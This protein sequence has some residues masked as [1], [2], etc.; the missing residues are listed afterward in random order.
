MYKMYLEVKKN[1]VTKKNLV[2]LAVLLIAGTALLSAVCFADEEAAAESATVQ[3]LVSVTENADGAI[4]AVTLTTAEGAVYNVTLDENGM[5]LGSEMADK[6][7]EVEGTV[8]EQDGQKT[9][10][11]LSYA[12]EQ[13]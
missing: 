13:E 6:K 5:K 8:A 9:I 10:T 12:A 3:G 2:N 7:V 11:V 1:M 4:T